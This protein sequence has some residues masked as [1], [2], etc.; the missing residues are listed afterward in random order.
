MPRGKKT[1]AWDRCVADL[2]DRGCRFRLRRKTHSSVIYIRE[3]VNGVRVRQF[4]SKIWHHDDEDQVEA[5]WACCIE[6][7]KLG[8]WV[9][10]QQQV[11]AGAITWVDL[12]DMVLDNLR[13]RVAREGSRKNAEG[14]LTTIR[15]WG[16][17]VT[18]ARLYTWV[19][20][21]DP[22]VQPKA[23]RNR[24]ETLSHMQKG[25]EANDLGIDLEPT[26][27]RLKA[28][29]PTGSAAKAAAMAHEKIRAIPEDDR[30]QAWPD[31]LEGHEQWLLALIATYGLR[32][33]EAWHAERI[34]EHGWIVVPEFVTKT[35][36]HIA[37]P[38]PAAWLQRY[39]LRENFERYQAEVNRRWTVR[40][41]ERDGLRIPVNNSQ[42]TGLLY[43]RVAD[44]IDH[45][46]VPEMKEWV[47]PYDLRHAYAIR[48]STHEETQ[49]QSLEDFAR[50][51]GHGLGVHERTYLRWMTATR[52]DEALQRRFRSNQATGAE[53]KAESPAIDPAEWEAFQQFK[54]FQAF[55]QKQAS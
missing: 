20:E 36:R 11:E 13:A 31:H 34:D 10:A 7:D 15:T 42:V 43:K 55:Q 47:R 37:P 49:G 12:A 41:E 54:A 51:M 14:H 44:Y 48:C 22:I 23:F 50:W 6:S 24:L 3:T 26:I 30:L 5:A 35:S 40:W 21:R 17:T 46:Y 16:G 32:P 18:P 45:L 19:L 39:Q 1:S 9:G 4:S 52:E 33:H 29:R 25:I 27:E 2:L 28:K 53:S 38:V 8:R